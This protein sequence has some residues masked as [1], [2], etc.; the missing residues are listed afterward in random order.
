MIRFVF[1]Q[2]RWSQVSVKRRESDI[3]RRRMVF[4]QKRAIWDK[5]KCAIWLLLVAQIYCVNK[6]TLSRSMMR[7]NPPSCGMQARAEMAH[8]S[9]QWELQNELKG[10]RL[11]Y[12]EDRTVITSQSAEMC[13]RRTQAPCTNTSGKPRVGRAWGWSCGVDL[14]WFNF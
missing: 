4:N 11:V 10:G 13:F 7:I 1:L 3:N 6:F 14:H 8:P 5:L 2:E 9:E 12:C